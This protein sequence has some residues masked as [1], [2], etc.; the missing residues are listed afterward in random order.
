MLP[1]S[2]TVAVS[3]SATG[4]LFTN[5][6]SSN[7]SSCKAAAAGGRFAGARATLTSRDAADGAPPER[8]S[9][10]ELAVEDWQTGLGVGANPDGTAPGAV[11]KSGSNCSAALLGA[12]SSATRSGGG[13]GAVSPGPSACG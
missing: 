5:S 4:A 8:V 11:D 1:S 13:C 3:F 9:G 7:V 2:G 12:K 10:R 6:N